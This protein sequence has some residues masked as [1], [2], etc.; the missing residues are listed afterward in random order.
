MS[1]NNESKPKSNVKDLVIGV[2]ALAVA[3]L[4]FSGLFT[5]A[6]GGWKVLDLTNLLG[7][8]GTIAEGT[9]FKGSG[10]IGAREGFLLAL[11]LAP[12]TIVSLGLIE[13]FTNFG[14]LDAAQ[15]F[16][17]PIMRPL[18]GIPG[19]SA[20]LIVASLS[21]SDASAAMTRNLYDEKRLNEDERDILTAFQYPSSAPIANYFTMAAPLFE[22]MTVGIGVPLLIVLL[23]K[24]FNANLIRFFLKFQ[25]KKTDKP[26][27]SKA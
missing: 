24:V 4:I 23:G 12:A 8:F 7:K 22:Y 1:E 25:S 17:T 5:S 16:L 10:G 9:N 2:I 6:P 14:A 15:K 3:I 11:T 26:E 20:V 27:E 13:V 19:S 21:S 18:M